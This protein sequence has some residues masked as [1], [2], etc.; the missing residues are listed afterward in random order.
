MPIFHSN[1]QLHTHT[2]KLPR[3]CRN[4]HAF[5][6]Q[7][8][9]SNPGKGPEE[10]RTIATETRMF[11]FCSGMQSIAEIAAAIANREPRVAVECAVRHLRSGN[12]SDATRLYI[13]HVLIPTLPPQGLRD[14]SSARRMISHIAAMAVAHGD[15]ETLDHIASMTLLPPFDEVC[16]AAVYGGLAG[17]T[18]SHVV[19]AVYASLLRPRRRSPLP[20]APVRTRKREYSPS[21]HVERR[22][23]KR[24]RVCRSP[25]A[26]PPPPAA[27]VAAKLESPAAPAAAVCSSA[28][29]SCDDL[30][31]GSNG[32]NAVAD[33][34]AGGKHLANEI[35]GF[36]RLMYDYISKSLEADWIDLARLLETLIQHCGADASLLPPSVLDA[37]TRAALGLDPDTSSDDAMAIAL[38]KTPAR[39]S[40]SAVELLNVIVDEADL[41]RSENAMFEVPED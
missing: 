13:M 22:D 33:V 37:Y 21:P 4:A 29:G 12:S 35:H 15:L 9:I 3:Q 16:S 1:T 10:I 7:L 41:E 17:A 19:R 40:D 8:K 23:A 28:A 6:A 26:P 32:L 27:P 31:T 11:I 24:Q 39:L 34:L 20:T 30:P 14:L 2:F 25:S 5:A 18:A 36:G 38:D